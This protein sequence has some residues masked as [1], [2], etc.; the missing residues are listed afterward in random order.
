VSE[1]EPP[2]QAEVQCSKNG[3]NTIEIEKMNPEVGAKVKIIGL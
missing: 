1:V 2:K 3:I